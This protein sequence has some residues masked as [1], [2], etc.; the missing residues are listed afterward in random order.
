M[1]GGVVSIQVFSDNDNYCVNNKM[2]EYEWL[3][4]ALIYG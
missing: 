1:S 2:L 3:L 4:T